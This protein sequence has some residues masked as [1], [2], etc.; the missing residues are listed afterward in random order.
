MR[1]GKADP[2][3]TQGQTRI[4]DTANV[5]YRAAGLCYRCAAQVAWGHQSGW[6]RLHPPCDECASI[7]RTFPLKQ[8][9]GW[10][11]VPEKS[12]RNRTGWLSEAV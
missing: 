2:P 6:S 4:W 10:R 8:V 11:S 12:R 5:W 9:N 3:E 1:Q 7:V